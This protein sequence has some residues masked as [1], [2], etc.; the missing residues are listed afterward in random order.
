[1]DNLFQL[2]TSQGGRRATRT[3]TSC[4]GVFQLTTSQG[5]RHLYALVIEVDGIFQLTTSQ[6]G[7]Q[8]STQRL[9]LS[10]YFNSRPHKEVDA[11]KE[12]Q[13]EHERLFQLT[14]SQGGRQS[15]PFISGG[16]I[17]FN[18]RPHKE[19]D[20]IPY[21]LSTQIIISTH[22]LT[23]RSTGSGTCDKIIL[24]EFQLTTSQGG[25]RRSAMQDGHERVFQLTTSQGGR[26]F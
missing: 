26:H 8:G 25:R 7:R 1:M 17:Y 10:R 3:D 13:T 16:K 14:T 19:V 11:Y 22:D 18:S 15:I 12:L 2:T 4:N 24:F 20:N 5:G 9:R 21:H 23:R 6:G